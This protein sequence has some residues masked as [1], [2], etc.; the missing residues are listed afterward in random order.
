M[1]AYGHD[2]HTTALM[3]V[4]TL[5][6]SARSHWTG[7]LV[8]LFQP[9][10]ETA[11]G[12]QA[13]VDNG[14]YTS[15]AV[16]V[17]DIVLDQHIMTIKA[18]TVARRSGPILA[19]VDS[20]EIRVFG[21]GGHGSRPDICVDPIV[22]ASHIVTRLQTVVSRE[23]KPGELAVISCGSFHGGSAANNI[24]NH[25]DLKLTARVYSP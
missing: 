20:F 9:N 23:V 11:G 19:G 6:E 15:H 22:T 3:D 17:P 8:C 16:P 21:K 24:P 18:G 1:H 14:L 13:M 2:M 10:E 7:T 12:A 4:A 25:V 5:L